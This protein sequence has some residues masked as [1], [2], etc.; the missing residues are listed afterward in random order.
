[1]LAGKPSPFLAKLALPLPIVTATK[2]ARKFAI[3]AEKIRR[4]QKE[5][6]NESSALNREEPQ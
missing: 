6:G 2:N 5:L 4:R 1:M 3:A